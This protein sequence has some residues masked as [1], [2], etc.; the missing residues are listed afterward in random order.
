MTGRLRTS[1]A[2]LELI[3]SFEGFREV[4]AR[5]PDGRWTVGYG[6]VRSAREGVT[7]TEQDAED[8]LRYDLQGIEEAILSLAYAPLTQSQFDALA[9]LVFNIS[10][11]QFKDSEVLRRINAGEYIAA[12]AGFDA[13]RK[14]RI[15]GRLIVVDALVRRRAMEK[16]MF[17][18]T[19]DGRP[20]APTPLVTPEI[21][22]SVLAQAPREA[23]VDIVAPL[24]AGLASVATRPSAQQGEPANDDLSEA[25]ISRAIG[26]M[27]GKPAGGQ[28]PARDTGTQAAPASPDEASRVVAERIAR[29][30][31]RAEQPVSGAAGAPTAATEAADGIPG[32]APPTSAAIDAPRPRI[33]IDD[34]EVFD[35][36]R[37]PAVLFADGEARERE[38]NG[39][40]SPINAVHPRLLRMA[41]WMAILVLSLLG[42]VIG[43]V[44]SFRGVG[45]DGGASGP[46]GSATVLAVSGLLL[47]MS[48][49]FIVTRTP[50][51]E[52]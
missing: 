27:V 9:S 43:I 16:A 35:P 10:P 38:V 41:P 39:F 33:F 23:I 36:G 31:K 24:K 25:A 15:N 17:L 5:I 48:I 50:D 46:D 49:Y 20:A 1:R 52:R 2:G 45:F 8:L 40:S 7:I 37:D 14:A 34:T 26:R 18:E 51:H 32:F 11:G 6:H 22:P 21:D 44:D 3:K 12:A 42:L 29:I 28:Q 47:I 4:A 13:W 30:L 19:P